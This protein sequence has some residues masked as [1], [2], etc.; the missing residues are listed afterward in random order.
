MPFAIAVYSFPLSP[1]PSLSSFTLAITI[2]PFSIFKM[3]LP[4][5]PSLSFIMA[6][7]IILFPVLSSFLNIDVSPSK[8]S[9]TM[10]SSS[11]TFVTMSE[12]PF[13]ACIIVVV[14][15]YS[16]SD[17]PTLVSFSFS[18][19]AFSA[20]STSTIF[21]T[22]SPFLSDS[23][24]FKVETIAKLPL[25]AST[26]MISQSSPMFF[27]CISFLSSHVIVRAHSLLSFSFSYTNL[28]VV[29]SSVLAL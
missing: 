8:G 9:I 12:L 6:L 1:F 28:I 15:T 23:S 3:T 18:P 24:D 27:S 5:L 25:S 10:P 21:V 14:V 7:N 2:F 16:F 26:I 11:T 20:F 17:F 22:V 29:S 13:F 19:S 4:S